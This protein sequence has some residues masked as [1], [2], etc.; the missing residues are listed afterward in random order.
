MVKITKRVVEAAEVGER[1]YLIWHDELPGFGLRVFSS[2]MSSSI[3]REIALV[4]TP[5]GYTEPGR[6]RPRAEGQRCNSVGS[7][8][9]MIPSKIGSSI[10]RR[11]P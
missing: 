1:D 8:G 6:Q 7:L 11:S 10:T 2:G 3:E 5:S 4:A 9:V